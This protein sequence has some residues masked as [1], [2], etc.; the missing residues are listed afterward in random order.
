MSELENQFNE[1][2]RERERDSEQEQICSLE[3]SSADAEEA[4]EYGYPL[5]QTELLEESEAD[6]GSRREVSDLDLIG[7]QPFVV[8]GYADDGHPPKGLVSIEELDEAMDQL[9]EDDS[10]SLRK[11]IDIINH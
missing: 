9:P 1:R 10:G 2:Q 8:S 6:F 7:G 11:I 3:E 4:E 5:P